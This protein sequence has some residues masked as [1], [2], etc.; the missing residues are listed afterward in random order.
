MS[1][2]LAI[3]YFFGGLVGVVCIKLRLPWWVALLCIIAG[4]LVIAV[5]D[6]RSATWRRRY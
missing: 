5:V 4:T 6:Y 1:S 3:G 2:G